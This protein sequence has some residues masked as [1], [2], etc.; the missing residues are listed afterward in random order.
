MPAT[1]KVQRKA[2][3]IVPEIA[4]GTSPNSARTM[5]RR[6]IIIRAWVIVIFTGVI[7]S[8]R[9]SAATTPRIRTTTAIGTTT[10]IEIVTVTEIETEIETETA[11]TTTIVGVVTGP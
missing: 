2:A 6:M 7:I 1:T 8:W 9:S 3:T 11:T 4:I 5:M 10:V